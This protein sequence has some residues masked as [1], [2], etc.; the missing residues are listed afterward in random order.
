M[1]Q[2]LLCNCNLL[3]EQEWVHSFIDNAYGGAY[4]NEFEKRK[5]S[6]EISRPHY[7]Y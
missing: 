3:F 7:K 2:R 1:I 6:I 5:T 4:N